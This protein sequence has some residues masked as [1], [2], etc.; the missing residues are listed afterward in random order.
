MKVRGQFLRTRSLL[1]LGF[2]GGD[3]IAVSV[4]LCIPRAAVSPFHLD[5]EG[6]G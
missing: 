5:G 3:S 1:P 2:S 4:T 6:L